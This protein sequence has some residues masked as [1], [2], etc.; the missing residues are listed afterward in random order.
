MRKILIANRG[1]IA[2]RIIKTA[3]RMGIATVA[4]YSD[5][6]QDALHTRMADQKVRVG[7]AVSATSYL[8]VERILAAISASGADA[9]HPGY[10][11][12]S[13]NAAFCRTLQEKGIAFI[14]PGVEAMLAMGDKIASK[15]LARSIGVNTIPGHPDAVASA[16]AAVAI[17]R[18]IGYPVMIKASAGGGGKGMCVARND[19]EAAEGWSSAANMGRSYFKD[20]R[21]FVEKFIEQPRHIEIQILCDQHGNGV[22]LNERECSIQRRNQ[23][24]I[25][26]APSSFV[27]AAMRTAMGEQALALAKAVGYVSAG[28]VEFVVG[29]DRHFHFLEMNTRLQVEHPVTEM[30]TGLDLVEE[31]IRIARGEPLRFGQTDVQKNGW[32]MECRIY[33]ENPYA[34]FLP[35]TGRLVRHQPPQESAWVRVDTGVS[36]GSEVSI[37]YDPMIAKLVTWGESR[38]EAIATMRDAL[39]NYL[40][41]GPKHNI[42]FLNALLAHPRFAEGALTTGFIAEQYPD[43]FR[44]AQLDRDSVRFFAMVAA[45]LERAEE[46]LLAPLPETNDWVVTVEQ[47]TIAL[48]VSHTPGF[49]LIELADGTI[50]EVAEVYRP[51]MRLATFVI[52]QESRTV[53]IQRRDSGYVLT[54]GGRRVKTAVRSHRLHELAQRMPLKSRQDSGKTVTTPMPGLVSR[55]MVSEGQKVTSGQILCLLEAMKMENT[56]CAERDGI[57]ATVHVRAGETVE[58]DTVLFTFR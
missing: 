35:S 56:L 40:I 52:G 43:G 17:A 24:V 23:K 10:G 15:K 53:Q 16:K 2:C 55:V 37:H 12:L 29:A 44:G 45:C 42:D 11:F 5:A 30:I 47:E 20:D 46:A 27:D 54:Q 9:V 14:G 13:E 19:A 31:M 39:D 8:N 38:N 49:D 3:R 18:E 28:T 6:D 26:E 58:N 48:R 25:E 41:E 32:A 22:W 21:V 51:G 7:E 1:E 36:A 4:I 34:N 57:I 33:A 50:L